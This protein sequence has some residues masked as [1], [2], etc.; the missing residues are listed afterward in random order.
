MDHDATDYWDVT[1]RDRRHTRVAWVPGSVQPYCS[2]WLTIHRFLLLNQPSQKS[3]ETDFTVPG[4]GKGERL[5]FDTK[6]AGRR[7]RLDRFARVI[8]EPIAQ[9]RWS[10]VGQYPQS[11]WP[12]FLPATLMCPLCLGESFHSVLYSL[13]GMHRCPV[14][15][16][17]F[18]PICQHCG[19]YSLVGTL[20]TPLTRPGRCRRCSSVFLSVQAAR[21]SPANKMRDDALGE[22][23]TWLSKAGSTVWFH[24]DGRSTGE[25][26]TTR[27][28]DHVS[29]WHQIDRGPE[30]PSKWFKRSHPRRTNDWV[31]KSHRFGRQPVLLARTQSEISE[32][33]A[34]SAIFKSIKR[35]VVHH[36]LES[37]GRRWLS[38]FSQSS[39]SMAIRAHLESSPQA[40]LA[41]TFM[42]WWQSCVWSVGLRDWFRRQSFKDV[43]GWDEAPKLSRGWDLPGEQSRPAD[44]FDFLASPDTRRWLH[45]WIIAGRL[46][47]LWW[48]ALGAMR[49]AIEDMEPIWG[50]GVL[51]G[52]LLPAWSA[53]REGDGGLIL[54]MDSPPKTMWTP[55]RRQ[56]RG[57]RRRQTH[58][59]AMEKK[60]AL[61]KRVQ[62][63]CLWFHSDDY[64]WTSGQGPSL[65]SALDHRKLRLLGETKTKFVLVCMQE[66][67][68]NRSFAARCLTFPIAASGTTPKG[69][70]Q[71][72]R[73][74]IRHYLKVNRT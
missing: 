22:I 31:C 63:P 71:G 57:E 59:Q 66:E 24:L 9:F 38:I 48:E 29:H 69:A 19:A 15:D 42:L 74:A 16:V 53:A 6:K 32:K 20:G 28:A 2:L 45:N 46:L 10:S 70:I 50:R 72:L 26:E 65:H 51:E 43:P 25:P 56:E 23:T 33:D 41:W 1:G 18:V 14:H 47:I 5:T 34:A 30:P 49:R 36:V 67:R 58:E 61:Q 13:Q 60:V 11:L 12:L 8:G 27:F 64:E 44:T 52:Q 35:Y 17:D 54:C 4:R 62:T 68:V 39:D 73:V 3:F 37:G 40:Q 7:F 55:A 21:A